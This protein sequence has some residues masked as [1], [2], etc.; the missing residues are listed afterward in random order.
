MSAARDY[1]QQQAEL[2]LPDLDNYTKI[3]SDISK[4]A[5]IYTLL[6]TIGFECRECLEHYYDLISIVIRR[7]DYK[8]FQGAVIFA[9]QKKLPG[10]YL[11]NVWG[12]EYFA[13][14]LEYLSTPEY[15]DL[16]SIKELVLEMVE[17]LGGDREVTSVVE[18]L[19]SKK[20]VN[21][22]KFLGL[23]LLAVPPSIQGENNEY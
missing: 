8:Y 17:V 10:P 1:N 2:H 6:S 13:Q 21:S 19:A 9:A 3:Y 4:I 20:D 23:L 11:V 5:S 7:T 12:E 22:L 18:E 16:D 14:I 15:N